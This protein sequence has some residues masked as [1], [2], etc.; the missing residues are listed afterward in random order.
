MLVLLFWHN[1]N[2]GGNLL[3]RFSFIGKFS[4]TTFK[5]II[6]IAI[7]WL[8]KES[9]KL[10][11]ENQYK[12][13]LSLLKEGKLDEVMSAPAQRSDSNFFADAVLK[14]W[15]FPKSTLENQLILAKISNAGPQLSEVTR[16]FY[17]NPTK[18]KALPEAALQ[19]WYVEW[20]DKLLAASSFIP[21][22]QKKML[23]QWSMVQARLLSVTQWAN[24]VSSKYRSRDRKKAARPLIGCLSLIE[25][26]WK[27]Y[28]KIE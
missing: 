19:P 12:M 16:V 18:A 23:S 4:F 21:V 5:C 11:Y 8:A 24:A 9:Q 1:Q 6:M 15:N 14:V 25:K 3:E 22:W 10:N 28:P 17:K 20:Q 7:S 2:T 13:V 27:T 26:F